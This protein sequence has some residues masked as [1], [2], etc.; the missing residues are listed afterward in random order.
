MRSITKLTIS[1]LSTSLLIPQSWKTTRARRTSIVVFDLKAALWSWEAKVNQLC[2]ENTLSGYTPTEGLFSC[3]TVDSVRDCDTWLLCEMEA[4]IRTVGQYSKAQVGLIGLLVRKSPTTDSEGEVSSDQ[5][6]SCLVYGFL[7]RL[8]SCESR[9]QRKGKSRRGITRDFLSWGSVRPFTG[10]C[11]S[12]CFTWKPRSSSSFFLS[13]SSNSLAC[14][15]TPG[16][17]SSRACSCKPGTWVREGLSCC[18]EEVVEAQIFWAGAT[19]LMREFKADEILW[20]M[21]KENFYHLHPS[22]R[23]PQAATFAPLISFAIKVWVLLVATG[24]WH[25]TLQTG[26]MELSRSWEAASDVVSSDPIARFA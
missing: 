3:V 11:K 8:L 12:G 9:I 6:H 14:F 22:K 21:S 23:E 13:R 4:K 26:S 25:Q 5:G 10:L 17:T 2:H 1:L 15:L 24:P 7:L 19:V 18:L 16:L 20:R